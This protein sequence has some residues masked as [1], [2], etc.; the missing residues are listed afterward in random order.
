MA[1]SDRSEAGLIG[2]S[3]LA[4]VFLRIGATAFGGMWAATRKLEA[5]LV[6]GKA[7]LTMDEQQA[8]MVAA[9]VIPAPK[10]LAFA[11][12][13]G[14]RLR[15][16]PGSLV[17][18][19]ALVTPAAL[20]VLLGAM[21]LSPDTLGEPL[22]QVRRAVG[23]AVVGLLFGNTWHQLRNARLKG[24]QRAAGVALACA[25]AAAAMAG[26]PLLLAAIAGFAIGA[27]VLR[28]PSQGA[29]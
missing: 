4:T 21:L 2:L 6:H 5:E 3:D 28:A 18:L 10:F 12:L 7:W 20:F 19:L 25:V 11:G 24:R 1:A 23:I 16:W 22:V 14:F 26:V 13:V 8:L 17:A 29:A 15:A 9:T 27:M